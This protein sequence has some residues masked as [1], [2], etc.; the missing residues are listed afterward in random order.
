MFTPNEQPSVIIL[1]HSFLGAILIA[2]EKSLACSDRDRQ[3]IDL[4]APL[5]FV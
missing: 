1:R 2:Y 4:P 3:F 5:L